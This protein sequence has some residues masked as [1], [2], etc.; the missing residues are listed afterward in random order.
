MMVSVLELIW[1]AYPAD[2]PLRRLLLQHS[3]QV[4][5]KA[6]RILDAYLKKGGTVPVDRRLVCDGAMLH[7]IGIAQCDA[8]SI[9]CQGTEPYMAHG[10]VG[11]KTVRDYAIARQAPDWGERMAR[12]CE[13]HTGTGITAAE[14]SSR[15]LPLPR[16]DFLPET[17][18]EKLVCLADKFFTKSRPAKELS[19][20]EIRK[21]TGK[22]G[23]DSLAR[24]DALC[25]FFHYDE[26]I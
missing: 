2:T 12:F 23:A 3:E 5:G 22:F 7:D 25:G 15:D 6:L 14:I 1:L 20:T 24:L 13:R 16:K 9:F 10:I 19:L 26:G 18:E 8:A 17:P 21:A 4:R 11:A